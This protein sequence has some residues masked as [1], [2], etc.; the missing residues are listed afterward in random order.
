ML[1]YVEFKAE[2]PCVE[3]P[4]IVA[5]DEPSLSSEAVSRTFSSALSENGMLWVNCNYWPSTAY[6]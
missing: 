5:S 4:L 6:M 2:I 3:E 1:P